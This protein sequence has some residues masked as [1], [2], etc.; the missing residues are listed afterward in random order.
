M[1]AG[2]GLVGEHCLIDCRRS[3]LLKES[4]STQKNPTGTWHVTRLA[5]TWI[6]HPVTVTRL[7]TISFPST[8][9]SIA[10]IVLTT[11]SEA[12]P[13]GGETRSADFIDGATSEG[14]VGP[15]L[16]FGGGTGSRCVC[17][18]SWASRAIA[19]SISEKRKIQSGSVIEPAWVRLPSLMQ[20]LSDGRNCPLNIT[21]CLRL[22]CIAAS[23]NRVPGVI[24]VLSLKSESALFQ[25]CAAEILFKSTTNTPLPALL[26]E[27]FAT[28]PRQ[29]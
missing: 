7:P 14:G 28:V 20:S 27:S 10:S 13:T 19:G 16:G 21:S 17:A 5:T 3:S 11:G 1:S 15:S 26:L 29:P 24:S 8:R 23:C 4:L 22:S 12:T 2:H 25:V 6:E 18:C 9:K